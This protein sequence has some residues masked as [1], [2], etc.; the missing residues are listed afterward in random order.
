MGE[1]GGSPNN[2]LLETV[3]V[4]YLATCLTTGAKLVG[5]DS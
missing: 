4:R 2:E 5:P 1:S 3:H